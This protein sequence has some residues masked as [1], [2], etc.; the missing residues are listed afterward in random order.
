MHCNCLLALENNYR[1]TVSVSIKGVCVRIAFP[2]LNDMLHV[3]KYFC[4]CFHTFKIIVDL[5]CCT[6]SCCT[7]KWCIHS[8]S[9]SIVVY[10]KRLN[11]LPYVI[12]K[13]LIAYL[14]WTVCIYQ[15]QTPHLSHSLPLRNHKS[16][17]WNLK[18]FLPNL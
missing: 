8:L 12:Q 10:P 7:V 6:N 18:Q 14:L 4:Y 17:L 5:Q 1:S 2:T 9:Y 11:M 13:D 16:I 15:P 3:W